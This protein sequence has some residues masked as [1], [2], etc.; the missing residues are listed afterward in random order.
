MAM[1]LTARNKH[2][3][4]DNTVAR[5]SPNDLLYCAWVRCNSMVTSWI[6]NAVAREIDDSL[7]YMP[8]CHEVWIDLCDWFQ[9]SNAPRI[10]QIKKL[11][12]AFSQGSLSVSSYYT[13]LR[14]LLDELR[15]Y[16]LAFVC[17]CGLMKDWVNIARN[18]L[19]SF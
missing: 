15:D 5:P 19:C 2:G 3:F 17:N 13:K 10:Y 1:A 4:V 16:Q 11:L 8:T 9:Q 18:V 7:I 14:T 6:L 12:S